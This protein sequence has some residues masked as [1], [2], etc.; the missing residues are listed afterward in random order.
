MQ[1]AMHIAAA[2]TGCRKALVGIGWVI[3]LL[4]T[5]TGLE[6]A[7]LHLWELHFWH[8][9]QFSVKTRIHWSESPDHCKLAN[10][11]VW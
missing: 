8:Y 7:P 11:W 1:G 4:L 5:Q 2:F 6:K 9:R 10:E 3:F